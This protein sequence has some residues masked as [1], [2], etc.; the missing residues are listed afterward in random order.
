VPPG[1]EYDYVPF[2]ANVSPT[3]TTEATANTVVTGNAVA[4]D[5]ATTVMIE[6]FSSIV[7]A[8]LTAGA[9]MTFCLYD[10]AASIGFIAA[11]G[12]PSTSAGYSVVRASQRLTPSNASHTYSIRAFVSGGTGIVGAG[13]GGVGA[14]VPGYI[15]QNEG[16]I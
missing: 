11:V 14:T 9:T 7:R 15:R 10:G 13:V 2:T 6:F 12:N 5:G 8:N 1:H 16:L 3:A 4:Y